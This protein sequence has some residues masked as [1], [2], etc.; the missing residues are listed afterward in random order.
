MNLD[1]GRRRFTPSPESKHRYLILVPAHK[2][3]IIEI[4]SA[5][6]VLKQSW[7]RRQQ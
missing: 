7:S 2:Q 4:A 5:K 3:R 6:P 1:G